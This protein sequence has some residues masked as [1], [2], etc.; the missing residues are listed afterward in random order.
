METSNQI[1]PVAVGELAGMIRGRII[2]PGSIE[3]EE[4]R[5]VRNGLIDRRPALI[6]RCQGTADVV[7]AVNFA[8]TRDLLVSVRGG[9]HNVA[10][11][12]VNDGGVVI[13]LSEMRAVSV[14]PLKMT[15]RA[16][17]GAT[18]GDVDRETQLFGLA[19]PGGVISSTGIGGLSLH[20]GWGWLRRK[21]G[22][23][24]DNIVS[25][26]VVTADGQVR[27]ASENEN[28]ELFWAIRGAGSNFGVVTSFE[29]RLHPVGPLVAL[30]ATAYAIEDAPAVLPAWR[31]YMEAAA[32]EIS[33]SALFWGIPPSEHFPAELHGKTVC[34]I[35][36]M[37][38]GDPAEGE[39]ALA[40]LRSLAE[41]VLDLSG[42]MPYT[43]LQSG[44]D[45]FFPKGWFYYWKS[46]YLN[47]LSAESM[48]EIINVVKAKPTANALVA[49][50]HLK[51]G[52]ASRVA[53]DAT[54]FGRRDRP[55][56]LSLDTTWTDR[57]HSDRCIAWTRET[58]QSMQRFGPGGLYLNFAGFGEEKEAL[59]RAGYG[60]NFDRLVDLKTQYDPG[61]LFRMNQN[62]RPR[63][64]AAA[65]D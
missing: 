30:A 63:E 16:Q 15:A 49:L 24:V 38:C 47:D 7:D 59:V 10:G 12:A 44:F 23:C 42:Q 6:I 29:F 39:A 37:H 50:W 34:V 51:G 14:D 40:P 13:D 26:E 5:T 56:L 52:A 11:N 62:I 58:W 17:G 57:A 35:A 65:A 19:T 54:A 32:D 28:A 64:M 25:A 2:A 22:Y 60:D 20:G 36:A 4:A 8:R 27:I 9:G 45:E 31:T 1:D 33:S 18:W 48:D 55:Y 43:A 53:P 46:L 3:Y 61:N 41:P 21:Y